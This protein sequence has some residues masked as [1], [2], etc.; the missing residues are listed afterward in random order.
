MSSEGPVV[1]IAPA[2]FKGTLSALDVATAMR[3]FL[4]A[5]PELAKA[6]LRIC[7][8]ADGGDDTLSVLQAVDPRYQRQQCRVMGPL[9]GMTVL[10][11]YL[12]HAEQKLVLIEAA[13]AH[14]LKLYPPGKEYQ[15]LQATSY[16]VGELIRHAMETH[17][18]DAVVVSL[19]GSASTDGGMGAL[20]ALGFQFWNAQGQC[21][22]TP[23][24]GGDL[25]TVARIDWPTPDSQY[26]AC[27]D[28]ANTGFSWRALQIVT[29]VVNPLL[30]LEGSAAVYA[31][32]K[33][34]SP[35]Q[36]EQL[37]AGLRQLVSVMQQSC[38]W[39]SASFSEWSPVSK[40]VRPAPSLSESNLAELPGVGAAGGLAYGLRCLPRAEI[41]SGSAWVASQLQLSQ[42]VAES[43]LILTGEGCLDATSLSGKATGHLLRLAQERG[44][45]VFCFCGQVR[46]N[47]REGASAI[48]HSLEATRLSPFVYPL[49]SPEAPHAEQALQVQ[50]AMADPKAA[51]W[52]AMA[53]AWPRLKSLLSALE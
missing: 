10:A 43:D 37:E 12:V 50:V 45:P 16:G 5:Q 47:W 3:D 15:P 14:G 24:G 17:H 44:K 49:V 39:V 18:P 26:S 31:P 29:D 34:A 42:A 1:L 40:A 7:P 33:G 36:C 27:N 2:A 51:L 53:A 35:E 22:P 20:Q 41:V 46:E 6:S 23:L 13:Q 30:G 38:V 4:R 28:E 21:L 52:R 9:P 32:Q 11:D 19:G 25:S 8:I 48:V